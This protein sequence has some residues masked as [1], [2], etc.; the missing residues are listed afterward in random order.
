MLK[1]NVR[2][3]A[4]SLIGLLAMLLGFLAYWQVGVRESLVSN[5]YNRRLQLN[6]LVTQRGTVQDFRGKILAQ[7]IKQ[8]DQWKRVFPLGAALSPVTGYTS[9]QLGKTGAEAV[10]DPYLA[11]IAGG[12]EI[13]NNVRRL[14]GQQPQG[15]NVFLTL[16]SG[17]QQLGYRLLGGRRGAV[18]IIEPSTGKVRAL[19]SSPSFDPNQVE[20]QWKQLTVDQENF[21]LLNRA[22]Q[23]LYPPGSTFKVATGAA[24][25]KKLPKLRGESFRCTGALEVGGYRLT[26]QAAHGWVD[27]DRALAVSCNT[28]FARQAL[29]TGFKDWYRGA[30]ELGLDQKVPF[31][32]PTSKGRLPNPDQDQALLAQ[33]AIGQGPILETPLHMALLAAGVANGGKVMQPLLLEKVETQSGQVMKTGKPEVWLT[34]MEPEI[35]RKL[36]K[37]MLKVVEEGTGKAAAIPGVRVAGKTGSAENPHGAAHAWFIGFAPAD[38]PKAAVAV[39]IENGGA[40]GKVAAPLAQELLALALRE[41]R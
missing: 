29:Q 13:K 37:A 21:L 18:V 39:L 38:Q 25:L 24:A 1:D 3:T 33:S 15:L 22:T 35:A 31:V 26:D 6:E 40:G 28:T 36:T 19:V 10:F 30:S 5:P 2:K 7:S 11:G 17:L 23:G 14:L 9:T 4:L 20:A 41:T 27:F 16:D 8:G 34:G 32:L 12:Q